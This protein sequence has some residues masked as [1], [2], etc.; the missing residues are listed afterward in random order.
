MGLVVVAFL[1][2]VTLAFTPFTT[3]RTVSVSRIASSPTISKSSFSFSSS[4]SSSS[5]SMAA[6]FV[7]DSGEITRNVLIA[8][9][10]GGGL[11]PALISAN[12]AMFT[13]LSGRKGYLKEGEEP[14][15]NVETYDNFDPNNTFDPT[16]G[17][18]KFFCEYVIRSGASGPELTNSQFLLSADKIPLVDIISILGRIDDVNSIADWKNLPSTK[19]GEFTSADPPMW[20]PRKAFKVLIRKNKFLGWPIDSKTGDYIGGEELKVAEVKRIS[21]QDALIGDASLDAVFDSWSWG[22][23]IATP[24]KVTDTLKIIKNLFLV[25]MKLILMPLSEQ[26]Y[27]DVPILPSQHYYSL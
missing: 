4:S 2:P 22:A 8:L 10:L 26:Q 16:M 19:R 23:S 12:G 25:R 14:D 15:K 9:T 21:K 5:L 24:D 11:I 20:L 18:P 3:T 1:A 6:E 7:P 17:D 13:A 27:E